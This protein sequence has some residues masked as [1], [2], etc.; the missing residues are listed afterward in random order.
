MGFIDFAAR[1]TGKPV[2]ATPVGVQRAEQSLLLDDLF[3]AH[4][5]GCRTFL[6]DEKHRIVFAGSVVHG[7]N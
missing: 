1:L 5:T 2:M 4:K 7:D 6:L 3:D